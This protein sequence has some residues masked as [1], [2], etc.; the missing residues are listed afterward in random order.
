[1]LQTQCRS[2]SYEFRDITTWSL[3]ILK[4]NATLKKNFSCCSDTT[5]L[6]LVLLFSFLN[7]LQLG[8]TLPLQYP[9]IHFL[10]YKHKHSLTRAPYRHSTNCSV[11]LYTNTCTSL[12]EPLTVIQRTA[13]CAYIQTQALP[14]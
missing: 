5:L 9:V 4:K 14:C 12:L 2:V 7:L 3:I 6:T 10:I 11:C 13:A 1:M 8:P